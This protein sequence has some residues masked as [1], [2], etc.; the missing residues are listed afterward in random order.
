MKGKAPNE[1]TQ[2]SAAYSKP[3]APPTELP[4]CSRDLFHQVS[5]Y[6]QP[7]RASCIVVLQNTHENETGCTAFTGPEEEGGPSGFWSKAARGADLQQLIPLE[8]WSLERCY[9]PD[10]AV[11]KMYARFAGFIPGVEA[12]DAAAFR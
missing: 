9:S 2:I 4:S 10:V 7:E 1:G 11:D 8:R 12:F 5:K 6:S 3:G